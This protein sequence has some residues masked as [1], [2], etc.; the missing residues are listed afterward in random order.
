MAARAIKTKVRYRAVLTLRQLPYDQ[1]L[2]LRDNI[3]VNGVLVP[4]L[5]DCG[6]PVCRIE[7]PATLNLPQLPAPGVRR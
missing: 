5:T 7:P 4:I 3:A 1:F 6:R 2:A